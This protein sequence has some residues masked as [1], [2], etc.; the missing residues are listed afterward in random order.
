M[1]AVRLLLALLCLI[2]GAGLIAVGISA[3]QTFGTEGRLHLE[4]PVL[5]SD[6][7]SY[8]LVIDVADVKTGLPWSEKFGETTVGARSAGQESLFVGLAATP[9]LDE[10]LRGVPYDVVRNEG[11]GWNL[12]SVP[13][14]KEPDPPR[15]QRF[16][17]RRGLGTS[18]TIPFKQAPG[19]KT[20]FVTM[21]ADGTPGVSAVLTVGYRSSGVVPASAAAIGFG[22]FLVLVA[23]IVAYRNR[24]K[25]PTRS[26]EDPSSWTSSTSSSTPGASVASDTASTTPD[27]SSAERG[28]G[29]TDLSEHDTWFRDRE[30]K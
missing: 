2:C 6:S 1:R 15:A 7:G 10:Y 29:G 17:T 5:E 16:W 30:N 3:I 13:G 21:N 20:T 26:R 18:A 19:G 14:T 25:R 4:S 12:S 27:P 8:A 11:E 23:L 28:S 22:V 24:K 9:E